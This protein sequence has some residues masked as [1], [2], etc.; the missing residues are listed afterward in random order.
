MT[1]PNVSTVF[2]ILNTNGELVYI[3]AV[4]D[5]EDILKFKYYILRS[6][7]NDKPIITEIGHTLNILQKYKLPLE[8]IDSDSPKYPVF[9]SIKALAETLKEKKVLPPRQNPPLDTKPSTLEY[10]LKNRIQ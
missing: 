8:H 6:T 5:P 10:K 1:E 3:Y 4:R 7:P 9:L 2:E